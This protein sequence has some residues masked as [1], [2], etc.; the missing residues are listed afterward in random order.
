M[1]SISVP[2]MSCIIML[3][4]FPGLRILFLY[5]IHALCHI[6]GQ[7]TIFLTPE[8]IQSGR[9]RNLA[10]QRPC[11]LASLPGWCRMYECVLEDEAVLG[12]PAAGFHGPEESLFGPQ[13]LNGTR[14]KHR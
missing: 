10:G 12:R 8:E 11:D 4:G 6:F 5:F 9:K 14:G 7:P 2:C 3:P 1:A 13:N